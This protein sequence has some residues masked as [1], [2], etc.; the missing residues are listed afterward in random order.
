MRVMVESDIDGKV[1]SGQATAKSGLS[2]RTCHSHAV[3]P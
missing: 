3:L 1:E 2:H